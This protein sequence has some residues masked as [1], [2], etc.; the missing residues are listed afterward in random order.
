MLL[1]LIVIYQAC[2]PIRQCVN[3]IHVILFRRRRGSREK[4]RNAPKPE[5][6]TQGVIDNP[7]EPGVHAGAENLSSDVGDPNDDVVYSKPQKK[8]KNETVNQPNTVLYNYEYGKDGNVSQTHEDETKNAKTGDDHDYTKSIM[9][10]QANATTNATSNEEDSYSHLNDTQN[11]T[12]SGG[13][14]N[15]PENEYNHI[16]KGL[17]EQNGIEDDEYD[18]LNE[19]QNNASDY[20]KLTKATDNVYS[21]CANVNS[22][23]AENDYGYNVAH[24]GEEDAFR[25]PKTTDNVY[26]HVSLGSQSGDEHAGRDGESVDANDVYMNTSSV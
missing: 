2:V 25:Q 18:H 14:P 11:T 1:K 8:K 6:Q 23:S 7:Q 9:K 19:V 15:M 13:R 16:G 20:P 12:A 5:M 26:S 21:R 24:K 22:D 4:E 10:T 17:V 3:Y